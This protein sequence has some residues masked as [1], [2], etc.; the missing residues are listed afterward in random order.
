MADIGGGRFSFSHIVDAIQ[1]FMKEKEAAKERAWVVE[2]SAKFPTVST[3]PAIDVASVSKPGPYAT[4]L[5]ADQEKAFQDWVKTNKV[6]FDPGSKSDYDMRGFFLALS[7]KDPRAATE[8]K[9]DGMHFP[10]TWKTPYHET[11]SNESVYSK[12]NAPKWIGDKL[13]DAYGRV[14]KDESKLG[15]QPYGSD[16]F[17]S[18][19]THKK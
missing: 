6:P 17:A 8:D 3:L 1:K 11:F 10:D 2:Q 18:Y 9:G 16:W 4:K 7:N 5:S 15:S 12:E 14:V 19:L 13:V